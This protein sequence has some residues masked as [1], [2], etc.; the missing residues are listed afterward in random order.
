MLQPLIHLTV[1]EHLQCVVDRHFL[2]LAVLPFVRNMVRYENAYA[3]AL[4]SDIIVEVPFHSLDQLLSEELC[5]Y[6]SMAVG[7]APLSRSRAQPC[8]SGL[9][10]FPA[11]WLTVVHLMSR[12]LFLGPLFRMPCIWTPE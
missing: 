1:Y 8:P 7:V 4:C 12:N 9:W 5:L 6:K 3:I 10:G 2:R 11:I